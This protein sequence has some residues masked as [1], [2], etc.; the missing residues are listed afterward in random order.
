MTVTLRSLIP[1]RKPNVLAHAS[2]SIEFEDQAVTVSDLRVL[3]NRSGEMW[4]GMPAIAVS[5]GGREY[6][7]EVCVEFSRELRRAVE[8]AVLGE[9][10]KWNEKRAEVRR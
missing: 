7:Y 10:A 5:N 3:R 8:D 2:V 6:S 4:V 9:F 1:P